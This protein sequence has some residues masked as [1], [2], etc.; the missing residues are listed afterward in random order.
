MTTLIE[1]IDQWEADS[2]VDKTDISTAAS[3]VD[4]LHSKYLR[5]LYEHKGKIMKYDS[6]YKKIRKLKWEYYSGKMSQE[7][8]SM[9]GWEPFQLKLK[10]DIP[11]YMESD[12]DLIKIQEKITYHEE[13]KSAAESIIKQINIRNYGIK[14]FIEWEKFLSGH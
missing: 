3:T 11:I 6:D 10:S 8:L 9:R 14:N 5:F 4:K 13:A 12:E 1:I 2:E 7:E